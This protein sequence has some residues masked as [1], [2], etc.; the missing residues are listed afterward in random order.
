VERELEPSCADVIL[1]KAGADLF[2]SAAA[3]ASVKSRRR[4]RGGVRRLGSQACGSSFPI[5]DEPSEATAVYYET[6]DSRNGK[7][8]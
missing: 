6:Y 7:C 8:L 2:F 5:F 1:S 3:A 4:P